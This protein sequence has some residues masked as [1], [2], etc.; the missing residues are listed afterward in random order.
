[1]VR[2]VRAS[3]LLERTLALLFLGYPFEQWVVQAV[4]ATAAVTIAHF[5]SVGKCWSKACRWGDRDCPEAL[6]KSG[7]GGHSIYAHLI[8]YATRECM[9][10]SGESYCGTGVAMLFTNYKHAIFRPL[11]TNEP[12]SSNGWR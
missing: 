12:G 1:M 10:L 4:A 5:I 2:W 6:A 3:S 8:K 9:F 7:G 11:T